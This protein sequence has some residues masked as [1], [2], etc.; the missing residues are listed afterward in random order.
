MEEKYL[1]DKE[2][3][4]ILLTTDVHSAW[5]NIDLL[6]KEI[7]IKHKDKKIDVI[8]ITGDLSNY[9]GK[10]DKEQKQSDIEKSESE[11]D[12]VLKEHETICPKIFYL[13]GNHDPLSTMVDDTEKLKK[14]GNTSVNI[15]NSVLTN[16]APNLI[17]CGYGGA[18]P[19]LVDDKVV[20]QGFPFAKDD[21]ISV[22]YNKLINEREELKDL[23]KE[24]SVIFL[25][26]CGPMSSSTSV[27][28]K[29]GKQTVQSG[30]KSLDNLIRTQKVQD[31]VF[32]NIHGHT[33]SG[34]GFNKIGSVGIINAGPLQFGRYA[35][36]K[37]QKS[38]PSLKRD[39]EEKFD[40]SWLVKE[41]LFYRL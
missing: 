10:L 26:H 18:G 19:G 39:P 34:V 6:K 35:I 2:E 28:H 3:I 29:I 17:L 20:W 4:T 7:E 16:F 9:P 30:S 31:N 8:F 36:L 40:Y 11:I 25:T 15:H 41:L 14:L 37:I 24:D 13:G 33:H 27:H 32:I 22:G 23:K 21:D 5:E 1:I 38:N 12:R